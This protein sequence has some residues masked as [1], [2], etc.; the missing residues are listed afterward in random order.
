MNSHFNFYELK[1]I[2]PPQYSWNIVEGC[3]KHP[4]PLVEFAFRFSLF[5]LFSTNLLPPKFTNYL[6]VNFLSFNWQREITPKELWH[7]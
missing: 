7:L 6:F 1:H 2:W 3:I 4:N 5:Q